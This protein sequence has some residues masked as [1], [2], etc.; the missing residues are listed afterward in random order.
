MVSLNTKFV[1]ILMLLG[2][3]MGAVGSTGSMGAVDST[4]STGVVGSTG[5][6]GSVGSTG[7]M[8][9]V[10]STGPIGV[11]DT[12]VVHQ[13]NITCNYS[14]VNVD[15]VDYSPFIWSGFAL[16]SMLFTYAVFKKFDAIVAVIC[17]FG[18]ILWIVLYLPEMLPPFAVLSILGNVVLVVLA[19]YQR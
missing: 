4:G 12:M 17:G 15:A 16:A 18:Q 8:G 14:V 7:S 3:S 9:V 11:L 6:I 5:S 1:I 13:I 2:V 10:G 19:G